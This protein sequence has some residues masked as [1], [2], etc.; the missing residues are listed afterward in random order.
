LV[1]QFLIKARSVY[2]FVQTEPMLRLQALCWHICAY[3][4]NVELINSAFYPSGVGKSS[5]GLWLELRRGV[6]TCVG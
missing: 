6:F 1:Y 3:I 4:S 2:E 5:T